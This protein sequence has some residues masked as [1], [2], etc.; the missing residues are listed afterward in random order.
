MRYGLVLLSALMLFT[1]QSLS[2]QYYA[3]GQDP[4]SIKWMQIKTGRFT[5]IY[6]ESY[7]QG[8]ISYARSLDEAYS[9]MLTIFPPRK[10][11]LPV[12]IHSYTIQ[13]NGYVA[14][15]P[16]RMELYPTPEQNTIPLDPEK[17]LSLHELA[18]V[19]QMESLNQ[20]FSRVMSFLFGEQ[21]TGVV[22]SLLPM[23][24]LEGDAVFAESIL[25]PSGRGRTASFQKPLKAL[26]AEKG[27]NYS[28]DKILNGSFR[29][30]V[31]DDYETGYQMVTW[32]MAKH[33]RDVW[34]RVLKFTAD[35]PFTINPVNLSLRAN[36]GLR[37]K[38]LWKETSDSL[39][40]LWMNEI[41][42]RHPF[43]YQQLNP[44]KKGRYINYYSP[45]SA[46]NDS[47]IA[48]KTSYFA[49]PAFVLINPHLKQ[50]K[51]ILVPGPVY[52]WLISYS[53]GKIVW[54]ETQS[55]PR[56]E[57]REYSIIKMMDI[58]TKI[59]VSLSR[60]SR[61]VAAAISPDGKTVASIENTVSNINNLVIIDAV[62]GA[63]I[64]YIPAPENVY[65][66]HP[67][68]SGDGKKLTFVFLSHAGE[69]IISY[70]PGTWKWEILIEPSREDLQSSFLKNDS[71]FYTSS[72][73]GTENIYLRTPEKK[74]TCVTNSEFGA[75]D[76]SADGDN[77]L[78]ANYSALGNSVSGISVKSTSG[79]PVE[80]A[81]SSFL[82]SRFG[83]QQSAEKDTG[84]VI[85]S[86]EPYRKGLHLFRFHS[87]LPFYADIQTVKSDPA[88]VRPGITIM[89][90]NS[91]STLTSTIG[92]EYSADKRNIFHTR[93][94][95]NGWY[96]VIES[97]LDWGTF[98]AISKMGQDVAD[99]SVIQTGV[100]FLNTISIP[101]QFTTSRFSQFFQPSVSA[102]YVNQYI[103]VKE[104][105]TYDHG[106]TIITGRLYFSN[107]DRSAIRD[108]YPRWAQI[109]DFNYC[110]APFDKD[111]YGS[112]LSLKTAF[113]FPGLFRNNGI[114]I[115][116]ETEN[117]DPAKY[118]YSN[119]S[120]LPRGYYGIVAKN[121][122][123][124][125]ID[126]AMPL[127]YPDFNISSLLYLKRIRAGL[128]YDYASGPGNSLYTYS[129]NGLTPIYDNSERESF[130]SFGIQLLADFHLLRIPFM[131]S[132]G[133]QSAWKNA[134]QAP[135]IEMLFNID[136]FGMTIGK[137]KM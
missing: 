2:A 46:G 9:R 38:A 82:I 55:D 117:Q 120:S 33:D 119:F 51:K 74:I 134:G 84:T 102:D 8:G 98:P 49:P 28:Y 25:S 17:Q 10:F 86:P 90:Q 53:K 135:D 78:F 56:W 127:A 27:R 109:F 123:F 47:I 54:V 63:L 42:L 115:R 97:Q 67:Q 129:G 92:Y 128:F 95:W 23:W 121:I 58:R 32:S 70:C 15:A 137:R 94:T 80:K 13:S 110:F 16:R 136:L 40:S 96:P 1:F 30:F 39:R 48:I 104:R 35:Q 106:Q 112:A 132:G 18:H 14:W 126:Y 26:L 103:Y 11:R 130:T 21:F 44:D 93:L 124:A 57:N 113:Y 77:I 114:K 62:T 50:E 7:G 68:W 43:D 37:K 59:I 122:Q 133:V 83:T 88:S 89:S 64:K 34:N 22:S 52:P 66:Q 100:S 24:F 81:T 99:P 45:L 3:T 71:L 101:L 105:S 79:L 5:V 4:A 125:S 6:P 65:L 36:I 87:W 111:I 20:G 85:Y 108:I 12:I 60:K 61:Y 76:I 41:S 69:G 118:L 73:S 72:S 19:M 131:I 75:I 107:Y 31:P 29:D 116:L 91:L